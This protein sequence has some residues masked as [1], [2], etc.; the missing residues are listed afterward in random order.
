MNPSKPSK[1]GRAVEVTVVTLLVA[2]KSQ[3]S[4]IAGTFR[5]AWPRPNERFLYTG[6]DIWRLK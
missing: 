3:K 2:H 4:G 1:V 5:I 6:D